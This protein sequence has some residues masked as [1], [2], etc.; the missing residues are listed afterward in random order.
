MESKNTVS[1][2]AFI[3]IAAA[4]CLLLGFT[5]GRNTGEITPL[6]IEGAS[7]LFGLSFTQA[8]KDSMLGSLE[9]QRNRYEALREV[10]LDNSVAPALVFNPLPSGFQPD[11]IQKQLDWGLATEISLPAEESDI[12]YMPVHELAVLIKSKKISSERLTKIYLDRIKTY[13]DTLQ[14]LI[15]L[16]EDSALE[17]AKAMDAEL[18]TGKYRGPLH[19]IPYGIKDLLAVKGTKTTWGAMPYKDQEIDMTAT[20]VNKLNDAG[21]VLVGKFTLGALAMGDVWY[22]GVTK[23]PWNLEQGASGS[24]AGSASAVSAGLVPFAIGTETLGSIV[25][26][27]TRNGV[28]GLRPTYG[29]VSKNGAMALS[30]SMDKIGPISRSALDDGIVLSIINGED[31]MDASTIKSA[32]NFSSKTNVKKLKV[33]YFNAYFEGNGS[34]SKNNQDV[35]DLL[36]NQGFELHPVELKTS[37]NPRAIQIMLSVEAAAAF[38]ELTRNGWDDQLVA[39]HKNAWPNSFRS[40]RFIPAVE[41]VQAARQRTILIEEMHEIMKDY[42]VIVTPSFGGAQ[43][44]ITNLTGHPALCLPNGF[45]ESG[46]PTSIT[47][48]ANLF[49][50]EKL[51]MLGDLIQKNSDWQA[52]RPPMF[53]K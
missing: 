52:K 18:A 46:S 53:D 29:R 25:S 44:Q 47:L 21:G 15:T 37:V 19:G 2:S 36:R 23:N 11:Q 26:P 20:V 5:L 38:D 22:G 27:S 14:C 8:E 48:L 16:V 39:Q 24:S 6:S 41:Y 30:W 1:S 51:V 13:S 50:E 4:G 33:G 35:L 32:F 31:A 17:K 34:G 42:D 10:K 3:L 49:E 12:A 7:E 43:L 40:A 9:N 45:S 28:T